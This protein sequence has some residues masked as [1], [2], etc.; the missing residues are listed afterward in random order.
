M[1]DIVIKSDAVGRSEGDFIGE[2]CW[3]SLFAIIKCTCMLVLLDYFIFLLS[4]GPFIDFVLFVCLFI[5][6]L[7]VY[8]Q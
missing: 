4:C 6:L 8:I 2:Y 1:D 7:A 5:G 3:A